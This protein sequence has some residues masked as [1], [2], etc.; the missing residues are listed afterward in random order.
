M[1][2]EYALN[3]LDNEKE[4]SVTTFRKSYKVGIPAR[5]AYE[6]FGFM[7]FDDSIFEQGHPRSLMKRIPRV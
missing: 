6:K 1:L 2:L 7:D 3:E 5:C 4:I